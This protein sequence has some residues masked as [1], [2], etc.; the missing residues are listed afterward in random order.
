M[1][2]TQIIDGHGTSNSLK[3]NGEGELS[4]VVHPHPPHDEEINSFLFRKYFSH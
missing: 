2:N 3:I 4:V 1:I